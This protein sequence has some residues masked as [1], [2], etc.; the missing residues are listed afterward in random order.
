[1]ALG[2]SRPGAGRK[3]WHAVP[4]NAALLARVEASQGAD[5]A[6]RLAF[7]AE[8]ETAPL[9]LRIDALHHWSALLAMKISKQ[10]FGALT[11]AAQPNG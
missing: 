10:A 2:G 8:D 4:K 5:L 6:Q 1:M 7:V 3:R 11:A 9:E